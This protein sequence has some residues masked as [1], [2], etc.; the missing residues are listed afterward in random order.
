M[1]PTVLAQA[2]HVM[3]SFIISHRDSAHSRWLEQFALIL[4]AAMSGLVP[5]VLV[6]HRFTQ[7]YRSHTVTQK[8]WIAMSRPDD[9][10]LL[11][12]P[13]RSA[14]RAKPRT[15]P[16]TSEGTTCAYEFREVEELGGR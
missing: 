3:P 8:G 4:V 10:R 14:P 11:R 15:P 12:T 16:N 7:P 13:A 9:V 6:N 1:S 5:D 2:I